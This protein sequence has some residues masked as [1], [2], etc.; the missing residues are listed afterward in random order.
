M[1]KLFAMMLMI[2][3]VMFIACS[4]D[5]TKDPLSADEAKEVLA[6]LPSD[7][8]T[9]MG[10]MMEAEGI[11]VMEILMNTPFPFDEQSSKS[12]SKSSIFF[13][14]NKYLLPQNY[15]D[16]NKVTAKTDPTFDFDTYKGTYTYHNTPF[17][18]WEIVPGGDK[19]V[20]NFPSDETAMDVNDATLTIYN[21]AE[22]LITYVE[23]TYTDTWYNPTAMHFDLVVSNIELIDV[24][25][26]AEWITT[27]D[28]AGEPASLDAII[29]LIPFQFTGEFDHNGTSA[30]ADFNIKYN[31]STLFGVGLD[32]KFETASLDDDPINLAGYIQFMDVK[33]K[34]DVD[35]KGLEDLMDQFEE[36]TLTYTDPQDFIDDL[37]E[38]FS[39]ALYVDGAKAAD[40]EIALNMQATGDEMPIDVVFVFDDG[41]TQSA[42]PTLVALQQELSEFFTFLNGFYGELK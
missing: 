28:E 21:Y 10:N 7:I 19:I 25:F 38:E 32:G 41:S 4:D 36:G 42:L 5:D 23:G 14:M 34:A 12:A 40:I 31:G 35:V 20:L 26:S 30:S 33:L 24:D 37:N 13:N 22:T 15:T 8:G 39:A 1:K 16:K 29:Y 3:S 2:A 11:A 18:Y 27:G 6:D 17:P 9:N